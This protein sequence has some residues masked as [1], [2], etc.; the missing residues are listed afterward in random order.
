MGARPQ[1]SGRRGRVHRQCHLGHEAQHLDRLFELATPPE[2]L[3]QVGAHKRH[4]EGQLVRPSALQ[5]PEQHVTRASQVP[6]AQPH[7][8][9]V[10]VGRD[11]TEDQPMPRRVLGHRLGQGRGLGERVDE[12]QGID[13]VHRRHRIGRVLGEHP[14][15]VETRGDDPRHLV[16][17]LTAQREHEREQH[18]RRTAPLP[19]CRQRLEPAHLGARCRVGAL[20]QTQSDLAVER[21]PDLPR[22]V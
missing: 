10:R 14:P 20:E 13:A 4:H 6:A 7:Q 11:G 5:R 2:H 17:A 3:P 18:P 22:T 9:G 8:P 1:E 21:S 15:V 19:R 12:H 16:A